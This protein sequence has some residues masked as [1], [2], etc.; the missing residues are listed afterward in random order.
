[1][2][3]CPICN[4]ENIEI[5]CENGDFLF[6]LT[7]KKFNL[8]RC[9][10]CG[11]IFLDYQF[12]EGELESF[13][14]SE[15]WSGSNKKRDNKLENLYRKLVIKH[16]IFFVKKVLKKGDSILDIGC[17]DGIFLRN[18]NKKNEYKAFCLEGYNKN[19]VPVNFKL[20][21]K[22]IE[23]DFK[24]EEKFDVITAFHLLEHLRNPE[25]FIKKVK[26]LL[27]PE[28][29]LI[30]QIPNTNSLQSRFF[31]CKWTGIDI[32]RH[33]INYS[34][35]NIKILLDKFN[36]KIEKIC[37]FSLRDSSPSIVCSIFP[38]LNP[39][40]LNIKGK[41]GLLTLVK[42]I[43]FFLLTQLFQPIAFLEGFIKKGGI[44]FVL[45]KNKEK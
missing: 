43:T 28:G 19:V 9:K 40:Y 11:G 3:T 41:S 36:F 44:I 6:K 4:S 42:K 5:Y 45:A 26:K 39:V 38:E 35:E 20:I 25:F 37:Y 16:H 29:S 34:D 23:E 12:K 24:I 27:K 15:Y 1:M 2:K 7:D 8:K 31:K 14:P 22:K 30:L 21:P 13:Y 18:L 32:P 17:G 10:K 33:L